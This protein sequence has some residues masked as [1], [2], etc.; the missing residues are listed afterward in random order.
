MDIETYNRAKYLQE[1]INL[2]K[3][4]KAKIEKLNKR[5]HDDEFNFV[6]E[7]S[8]NCICLSISHFEKEFDNL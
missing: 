8:H 6:R 3:S 2:L 1:Q 4:Q 5:N 7:L